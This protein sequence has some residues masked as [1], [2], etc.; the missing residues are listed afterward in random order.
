MCEMR[1]LEFLCNLS[2][3]MELLCC[4]HFLL[5]DQVVIFSIKYSKIA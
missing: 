2:R 1:C 5:T 4:P 3:W